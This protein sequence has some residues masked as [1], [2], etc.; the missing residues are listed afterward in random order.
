MN[1]KL[2]AQ[3]EEALRILRLHKLGKW[4]FFAKW[5]RSICF[6]PDLLRFWSRSFFSELIFLLISSYSS[7]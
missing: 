2:V 1:D 4:S 5:S 3:C 6:I 7:V